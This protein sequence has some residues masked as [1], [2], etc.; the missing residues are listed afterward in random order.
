MTTITKYI[1]VLDD[2][3]GVVAKIHDKF[4]AMRTQHPYFF[5]SK[6]FAE[7]AADEVLTDDSRIQ[8]YCIKKI[9]L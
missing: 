1:V 6:S 4:F 2:N 7:E 5:S 9:N 3:F 8:G